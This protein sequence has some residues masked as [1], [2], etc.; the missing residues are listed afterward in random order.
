MSS[1]ALK[2]GIHAT[3][4]HPGVVPATWLAGSPGLVAHS[5]PPGGDGGAVGSERAGRLACAASEAAR[6]LWFR[7]RRA[8]VHCHTGG[9]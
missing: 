3:I 6:P 9:A 7:S 4:D 8:Y 2:T 5:H 1:N